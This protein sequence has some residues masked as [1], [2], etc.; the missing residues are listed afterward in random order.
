[1][2]KLT[3]L[4]TLLLVAALAV[5]CQNPI[6]PFDKGEQTTENAQSDEAVVTESPADSTE[7][8]A[9]DF[10]AAFDEKGYW[11]D[12]KASELV[13]AMTYKGM[14]IPKSVHTV[15]D[16]AIQTEVDNLLASFATTEKITDAA[17]QNGDT[18]NI[19]YVGKID[20][21]AFEGGSTQGMGTT[22]TIGV[23]SYI[24]DFLEQ[25]IGHKPGETFDIEVTFP[26]NYHATDLAGKDAIFTVTINYIEGAAITPVFDNAFVEA[27]LTAAYGWKTTDEVKEQLKQSLQNDAIRAYVSE[28]LTAVTVSSIPQSVMEF[29][30]AYMMDTYRQYAAYYSVDLPT[31]LSTYEGVAD[32]AALKEKY[33]TVNETN[34][35][36]SLVYQA[37][38]EAESIAPSDADVTAY[39]ASSGMGDASQYEAVYGMNYLKMIAMN[40]AVEDFIIANA[41]PEQ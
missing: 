23:T 2:K 30:E 18:V 32:E 31:F 6:E 11:K 22:V 24:D 15:S 40:A 20:G 21:V 29:Q 34:A 28:Q 16:D 14:S 9:L 4:L 12:V 19:D 25:L 37:I 41:V 35:K 8:A 13:A 26:D 17:L 36:L 5:S 10:S 39:F 7:P 33:K 1:M 27:N 38:A 3:L